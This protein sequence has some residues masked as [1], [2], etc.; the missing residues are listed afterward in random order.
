MFDVCDIHNFVYHIIE[1]R[2]DGGSGFAH[3]FLSP[4]A[5]T[6]RPKRF[7]EDVIRAHSATT[8]YK[9]RPIAPTS[10]GATPSGTVEARA[11]SIIANSSL[12]EAESLELARNFFTA[13]TQGA[14]EG[15]LIVTRFYGGTTNSLRAMIALIKYD[16]ESVLRYARDGG[17]AGFEEIT[18]ALVENP[19]SV[20]KCAIIDPSGQGGWDVLVKDRQNERRGI[21]EYFE[22]FL[23]VDVVISPEKATKDTVDVTHSWAKSENRI[24]DPVAKAEYQHRAVDFFRT[25]PQYTLDS[26]LNYVVGPEQHAEVAELRA[27]LR[28]FLQE[29]GCSHD[30]ESKP[31]GLRKAQM[32]QTLVTSEDVLIVMPNG[33]R[34]GNVEGPFDEDGM[35][36][37]KIRSATISN[38]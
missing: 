15:I 13:H 16:N 29:N 38:R 14:A 36:V 7:F 19:R 23:G 30:F 28:T 18:N 34:A 5:L 37:I 21:A 1:K 10:S 8:K 11:R 31:Q 35:K 9:F 12:F 26:F 33:P 27:S 32:K 6:G 25:Q 24:A 17:A 3:R 4:I 22:N 2:S 20:M